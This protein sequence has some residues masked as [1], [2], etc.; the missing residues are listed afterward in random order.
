M[1]KF[2]LS[3]VVAIGALVAAATSQA[4]ADVVGWKLTGLDT[5]SGTLTV[6]AADSGGFDI[7]SFTGVIDG[8]PVTLFG[9]NPGYGGGDSGSFLYDNIL[10]TSDNAP[11][12]CAGGGY[13]DNCGLVFLYL[14]GQ[15]NLYGNG[16]T[17]YAFLTCW[18]GCYGGNGTGD[19]FS[20]VAVPE[21]GTLAL[22]GTGL[23]AAAGA[24]RRRKRA[25]KA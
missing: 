2:L 10:F 1:K 4:S 24:L 8:N 7:T 22:M 11:A 9:G 17:D 21:P 12:G 25:P 5:G 13:L 19:T 18:N 14:G 20:L 16:G 23:L 6:G 15:A 3:S